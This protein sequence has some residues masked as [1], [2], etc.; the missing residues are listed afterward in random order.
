MFN[1][2]CCCNDPVSPGS[3]LNFHLILTSL[4]AKP[5][6]S[7]ELTPKYASTVQP[8]SGTVAEKHLHGVLH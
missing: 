7:P 4:G 1:S 3:S 5:Q 6:D 8:Q 2:L